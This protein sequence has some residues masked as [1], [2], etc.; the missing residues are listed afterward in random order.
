MYEQSKCPCPRPGVVAAPTPPLGGFGGAFLEWCL[1]PSPIFV[2]VLIH[3]YFCVCRPTCFGFRAVWRSLLQVVLFSWTSWRCFCTG[4]ERHETIP[5]KSCCCWCC[6]C[7]SWSWP[8]CFSC[9]CSYCGCYGCSYSCCCCCCWCWCFANIL[10]LSCGCAQYHPPY[11]LSRRRGACWTRG[12]SKRLYTPEAYH[13]HRCRRRRFSMSLNRRHC[14]PGV[15]TGAAQQLVLA[16]ALLTASIPRCGR[17]GTP[18]AREV[19]KFCDSCGARL[20]QP[21]EGEVPSSFMMPC[22]VNI[23]GFR[24]PDGILSSSGECARRDLNRGEL[25]KLK[26]VSHCKH[27][28]AFIY[29]KFLKEGSGPSFLSFVQV[30]HPPPALP[31]GKPLLLST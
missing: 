30:S 20:S 19:S 28:K 11:C 6:C 16:T 14:L 25:C 17:C 31:Q 21:F 7:C 13:T 15:R 27:C 5:V 23:S 29:C 1:P 3:F 24:L 4:L 22:D 10:L 8:C 18:A 2:L 9:C 12:A 26:Q